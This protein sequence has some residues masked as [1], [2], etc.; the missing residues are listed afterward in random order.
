[1]DDNSFVV[2]TQDMNVCWEHGEIKHRKIAK[3]VMIRKPDKNGSVKKIRTHSSHIM[4]RVTCRTSN[5]RQTQFF[6]FPR[7]VIDFFPKLS[8][9]DVMLRLK[10]I[11]DWAHCSPLHT[12]AT[13]RPDVTKIFDYI[14]HTA[15]LKNRGDDIE[16][17]RHGTNL[18]WR[19]WLSKQQFRPDGE[20]IPL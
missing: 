19:L 20:V 15:V 17:C 4:S 3:V 14:K 1:M 11:I 2:L 9:Q 8:T 10:H 16:E 5:F 7:A 12:R 6:L 13:L 18:H